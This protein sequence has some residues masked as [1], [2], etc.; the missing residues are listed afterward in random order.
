MEATDQLKYRFLVLGDSC[1][2]AFEDDIGFD[3]VINLA[4]ETRCGHS[5]AVYE[6]GVYKLSINCAKEAAKQRVKRFVEISSAEFECESTTGLQESSPQLKPLTPLAKYKLKVENELKEIQDLDYVVLRPALVYGMGDR[7]SLM[8]RIVISCV[9]KYLNE[10][11]KLL[12]QKDHKLHTIHVQDLC[13]AVWFCCLNGKPNDI[14][15][16]VDMGDTTQGSLNQILC[17]IFD[18][19]CDYWGNNM[20]KIIVKSKG[21]EELV[22]EINEKH[23]LGWSELCG[24]HNITNTPINPYLYKEMLQNYSLCLNGE[25]LKSLGFTHKRPKMTKELILEIIKDY[26]EMQLFPKIL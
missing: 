5:D 18:I 22:E 17:D 14:Y 24:Q 11:M 7:I 19:H 10:S 2:K 12:W 8:P 4:S 6:E 13:S 23:L 25:K 20:S 9:Y 3:F 26:M 15:N 1:R 21:I 16:V